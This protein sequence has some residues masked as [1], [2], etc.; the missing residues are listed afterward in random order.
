[1]KII[2]NFTAQNLRNIFNIVK[3]LIIHDKII[4][5]FNNNKYALKKRKQGVQ[6]I[7]KILLQ[8]RLFARVVF[9]ILF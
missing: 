5:L 9:V 6:I 1:V 8:N 2:N 7:N 4:C 3:Y